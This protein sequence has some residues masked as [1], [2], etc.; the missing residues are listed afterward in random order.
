MSAAIISVE[1][2]CSI[3]LTLLIYGSIFEVKR[4][5]KKNQIYTVSISFTLVAVITDMCAWIFDRNIELT[6]FL[7]ILNYL[8]FAFGYILG[9]VF[10]IYILEL[11]REK[12]SLSRRFNYVMYIGGVVSFFFLT[13]G[14]LTKKVFLIEDGHYIVGEWYNYSQIF[15]FLVMF[16]NLALIIIHWKTIG[17]H[18]SIALLSYILFPMISLL[19]HFVIPELSLSY[20]AITLSLI[21]LYIMLQA[22]QETEFRTR[23]KVLIEV[24]YTDALTKLK[25]RRAYE[26]YFEQESSQTNV[27]VVFCDINGL[28]YANDNFGHKAGDKLIKDFADILTSHFRFDNI[29]RI[30]GDEFVIIMPDISEEI[31]IKRTD[32]LRKTLASQEQPI[33][34]MGIGYGKSGD[35]IN[36]IKQAENEM[37]VN[38]REF[39]RNFPNAKGR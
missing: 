5:N 24:S 19:L 32:D 14:C 12:R 1:T 36:I 6:G 16:Y 31:Y 7:Y 17:R 13:F 23:E 2:L 25:N 18:D 35:L 29:Y 27:G 9:I 22:E 38:K 10:N 21:T 37:Y 15:S 8:S 30:S 26:D 4:K 28:K 3:I 34:S 20:V 11:I 33:A 39:H